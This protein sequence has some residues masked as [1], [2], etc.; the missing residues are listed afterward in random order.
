[1]PWPVRPIPTGIG[2][3]KERHGTRA[4]RGGEM[5]WSGVSPHK[6]PAARHQRR[7]LEE[8]SGRGDSRSIG[9]S[10]Y[11][12]LDEGFFAGAPGE[13]GLYLIAANER[14][15][16]A[17]EVELSPTFSLP[18]RPGVEHD[19]WHIGSQARVAPDT[20]REVFISFGAW[21]GEAAL[22]GRHTQRFQQ[23]YQ[24]V[25]D[26]HVG[27]GSRSMQVGED[28]TQGL[29]A[30]LAWETQAQRGAAHIGEEATLQQPLEVNA[31]VKTR[32]P[33]MT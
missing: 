9:C 10:A 2:W 11:H 15:V 13:K 32:P 17:R 8:G 21:D 20:C 28:R 4:H 19:D 26:M 1:M 24:L 29:A 23:L 14:I 30:H 27:S 18:C 31:Q 7:E 6:A 25:Y 22:G 12:T 3:T 16:E 33:Q 5:Q